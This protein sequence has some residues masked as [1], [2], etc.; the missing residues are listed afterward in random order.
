MDWSK[1]YTSL[2]YIRTVDRNSWQDLQRIDITEGKVSR[3]TSELRESASFTCVDYDQTSEQWVRVWL[4]TEQE[5]D[6]SHTA[7]FTGLATSPNRDINGQLSINE[8]ECYSVLKPAQDIILQRG[9]YAPA[10]AN[11]AQLVAQLLSVTPAPKEIEGE[12]PL[13]STSYVAEDGETNLSMARKIIEAINWRLRITGD[14]VIHICP[15]ATAAGY[16]FNADEFDVIEPKLSTSFDW[17]ACPNVFRAVKGN[18]S[19]LA[20]DNDHDS[21]FSTVRRHREIWKEETNCKLNST[22]SLQEYA[23]RRLKE[24]QAVT[25]AV[26]YDRRFH[27]DVYVGDMVNLHYPAQEIEGA[28]TIKSQNIELRFGRTAEKGERK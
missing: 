22:E 6:V 3:G 8:V 20:I 5:G 25:Y 10:G 4:D 1:G 12:S 19:A 15:K 24:E 7:I 28:F 9:W 18:L 21:I 13:L 2:C 26:S 14:G 11:G 27:P 23:N 16:T 17:Y